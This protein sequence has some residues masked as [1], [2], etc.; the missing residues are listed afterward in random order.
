MFELVLGGARSGKSRYAM[1]RALLLDPRP[2]YVATAR[3]M[4]DTDLQQRIEHH[5]RERDPRFETA[6]AGHRPEQ[7]ALEGR[8]AVVDCVTLWLSTVWMEE[9]QNSEVI[10]RRMR[11]AVAAMHARAHHLLLISNEIGLG[12]HAATAVGRQ[13]ADLQG[14]VNQDMAAQADRVT[15]MVAG[16]PLTVKQEQ[17]V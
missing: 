10:R 16:L 8:T 3:A 5:R 4:D 13:F 17:G 12:V 9:R 7:V 2:L 1:Q 11:E 6:E 15:L 14:W